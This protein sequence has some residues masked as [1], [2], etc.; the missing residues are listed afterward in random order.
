MASPV[1]SL[2]AT[3][4]SAASFLFHTATITR[5]V[6]AVGSDPAD[7]PPPTTTTYGCRALVSEYSKQLIAGG[8]AEADQRNV[9]ILAA[10]L[11]VAPIIGD[12]ITLNAGPF[13][14]ETFRL[15]EPIMTDPARA[16][17]DCKGEP[18]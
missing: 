10:T 4:G 9:L 14:G 5:D 8:F 1:D 18:G 7:P 3:F 2:A 11:S 12:K 13:N 17:W 15:L 6:A 16:V